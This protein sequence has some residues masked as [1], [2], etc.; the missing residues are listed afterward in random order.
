MTAR[1]APVFLS[2]LPVE[3][4]LRGASK[5]F[6]DSAVQIFKKILAERTFCK[7]R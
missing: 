6:P 7:P 3:K 2:P 4:D 5:D 1:N